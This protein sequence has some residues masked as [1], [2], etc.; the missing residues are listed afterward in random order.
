MKDL[1][2]REEKLLQSIAPLIDTNHIIMLQQYLTP[3]K[4]AFQNIHC[5]SRERE[6]EREK[7]FSVPD[8]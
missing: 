8:Q 6:R 1:R 7:L 2:K 5:D 4:S 3:R